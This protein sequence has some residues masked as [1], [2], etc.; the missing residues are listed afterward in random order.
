MHLRYSFVVT[1]GDWWYAPAPPPPFTNPCSQ[2]M[3]PSVQK[4]LLLHAHASPP[5]PGPPRLPPPPPKPQWPCSY[6][7]Q[8]PV[9]SMHMPS[10]QSTGQPTP[11]LDPN[12]PTRGVNG[13]TCAGEAGC[14]AAQGCIWFC[15]RTPLAGACYPPPSCGASAG[16]PSCSPAHP[17]MASRQGWLLFGFTKGFFF[18]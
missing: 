2:P 4:P 7:L 3:H 6:T 17:T 14:A 1:Y 10:P 15:P 5:L 13:L 12:K 18:V 8:T 16:S 9:P 11:C